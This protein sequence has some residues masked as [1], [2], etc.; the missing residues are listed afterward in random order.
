V[1]K[2]SEIIGRAVVAREGAEEIGKIK[3]LVVEPSG[4][5]VLGFVVGEGLFSRAKV[6]PW[7]GVQAIGPDSVILAAATSV[8]KAD[9]APDIKEVLDKELTIRGLRIQTTDGKDL[10]KIDD[11]LFDEKTGAV[12]GYELSGGIFGRNSFMPTPMTLELGKDLAFV[13]PETEATIEKK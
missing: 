5:Q 1:Q 4:R 10:G 12:Q 3:D 2:A 13:G 11:F 6:A 7:M 9:E 8:V